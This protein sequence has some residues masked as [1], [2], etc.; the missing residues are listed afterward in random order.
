MSEAEI[1]VSIIILGV[2]LLASHA[3]GYV[4]ERLSQP[5][6]I[7]EILAGV[8]LGPFV[9]GKIASPGFTFLFTN[10]IL[11]PNKT[12]L[13]LSFVYWL[14]LL[15]LMFISGSEVQGLLST[16]NR[17]ETAWLLGIGTPLPF[18]FIVIIG[19]LGA[20]PMDPLI[21]VHGTRMS[22]LLVLASAVAVT[23][24]PVISRIF[25]DLGILHTRFASLIL[26]TAM[27]E[28]VGLWG[29]LAIATALSDHRSSVADG[30]IATNAYHILATIGYIVVAMMIVPRLLKTLWRFDDSA[31]SQHSLVT[32][33]IAILCFFVGV[34]AGLGVS[35]VFAAF[36]AGYALINGIRDREKSAL[37]VTLK[38]IKAVAFGVF[39]PIYFAIVGYRLSFGNDFSPSMLLTFLVG[40][41]LVV[42]IFVGLAAKLAG[43]RG[44]DIINFAIVANARGGPGIVLASIAFDA[45]L[46]SGAFCTTLVIT[47]LFTSQM[48]GSWLR[49]VLRRGWPLLSTNPEE[50]AADVSLPAPSRPLLIP[51]F[52]FRKAKV[53]E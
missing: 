9:L 48:A 39:V 44:L 53:E 21:G 14:G 32:Y 47:A 52:D 38:T 11:G 18:A 28:D 50:K 2:F 3:F 7:G 22:A 26:G 49:F 37:N 35:T 30:L 24:I 17:H 5:R 45:G 42:L 40:S 33:A 13:V 29:V 12:G 43:F 36:L 51:E 31:V 23:S 19:L 16:S 6:L 8:V 46:I 34:A 1:G 4:A 20:I 15:L 10:P 41:T 25:Q 27:L